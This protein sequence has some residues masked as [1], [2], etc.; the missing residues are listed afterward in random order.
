MYLTA[1]GRKASE[2]KFH[3]H[4]AAML[5]FL[6]FLKKQVDEYSLL[7]GRFIDEL[8]AEQLA[9]SFPHFDM[10][11]LHAKL[12]CG[13]VSYEWMG[14]S[15]PYESL[16]YSQYR[17]G[18]DRP[19][20]ILRVSEDFEDGDGAGRSYD[21][22]ST[23][24]L[25]G[26]LPQEELDDCIEQAKQFLIEQYGGDPRVVTEYFGGPDRFPED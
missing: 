12:H 23:V 13:V 3:T 26:E 19:T 16:S 10:L 25:E 9:P 18:A 21:R 7:G 2:K 1:N 15:I 5:T 4:G 6:L 22:F 8:I 20:W 11:S 24:I 14:D 17:G